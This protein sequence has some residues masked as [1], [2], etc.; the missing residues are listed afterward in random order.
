MATKIY[1]QFLLV[2]L[3][4]A[5]FVTFLLA[6]IMDI[7]EARPYAVGSTILCQNKFANLELWE[8]KQGEYPLVYYKKLEKDYEEEEIDGKKTGRKLW[9]APPDEEIEKRSIMTTEQWEAAKDRLNLEG[10]PR[11]VADL[12]QTLKLPHMVAV[13]FCLTVTCLVCYGLVSVRLIPPLTQTVC[14]TYP[15]T[16]LANLEHALCS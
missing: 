2:P 1:L 11:C 10:G 16:V 8:P 12:T 5:Y 6:P 3:A 14:R 7:V 15:R 9:K 13:L 4:L